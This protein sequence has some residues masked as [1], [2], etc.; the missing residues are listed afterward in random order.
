MKQLYI[1]N[2]YG[3]AS[4]TP[5][6]IAKAVTEDKARVGLGIEKEWYAGFASNCSVSVVDSK[7]EAVIRLSDNEFRAIHSVTYQTNKGNTYS[8]LYKTTIRPIKIIEE[9]E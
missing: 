9:E 5:Q 4:T 6:A 2:A 1:S 7:C 3:I 8:K